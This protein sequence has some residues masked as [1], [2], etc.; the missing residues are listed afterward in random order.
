[1]RMSAELPRGFGTA[2]PEAIA[3]DRM[4]TIFSQA[5]QRVGR[6]PLTD[7]DQLAIMGF[8]FGSE[9]YPILNGLTHTPL[10]TTPPCSWYGYDTERAYI[11]K[12]AAAYPALADNLRH[13]FIPDKPGIVGNPNYAVI[14]HPQM[15]DSRLRGGWKGTL[16]ALAKAMPQHGIIMVHSYTDKE[17]DLML[18]VI[19]DRFDVFDIYDNPYKG[20]PYTQGGNTLRSDHL[21]IYGAR[22]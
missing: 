12:A 18:P 10:G 1:M 11:A 15:T 6:Q 19:Q 3:T 5:L 17:K 14:R 20:Y 13:V 2:E 22:R 21:V 4:Y 8:G 9:L 7:Q 16:R